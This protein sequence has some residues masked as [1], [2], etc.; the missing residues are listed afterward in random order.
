MQGEQS[1]IMVLVCKT[2]HLQKVLPSFL[3]KIAPFSTT[4]Y[5]TLKLLDVGILQKGS[6]YF[7]GRWKIVLA[8]IVVVFFFAYMYLPVL[9]FGRFV[10]RADKGGFVSASITGAVPWVMLMFNLKVWL[11]FWLTPSPLVVSIFWRRRGLVG[12]TTAFLEPVGYAT[13]FGP[14]KWADHSR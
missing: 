9:V 12:A 3:L 10:G 6:C 2:W 7:G 4:L 13:V 5:F 1:G 11:M 8:Y 14:K